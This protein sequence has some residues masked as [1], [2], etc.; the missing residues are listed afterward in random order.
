MWQPCFL[1]QSS[2]KGEVGG[3]DREKG[4]VTGSHNNHNN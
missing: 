3:K 4:V 2:E 1:Q